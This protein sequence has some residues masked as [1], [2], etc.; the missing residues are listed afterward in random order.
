MTAALLVAAAVG[1]VA[2]LL[3]FPRATVCA[4]ALLAAA[5]GAGL[6]GTPA[7]ISHAHARLAGWQHGQA[8]RIVCGRLALVAASEDDVRR[9][10]AACAQ[11]RR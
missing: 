3:R 6:V 11:A 7:P 9:A 5:H 4:C 10:E 8:D 2:A 1:L